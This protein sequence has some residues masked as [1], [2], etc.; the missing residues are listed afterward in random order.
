MK[1][2]EL[3]EKQY[4]KKTPR[5]EVGDTLSVD[6]IVREGNKKRIQVFTGIVLA[7]KGRGLNKTF[8]IR[9]ISSGIGV[10]KIFPL[11]S[12]NIE[13][14]TVV[15]SGKVRRSK[16]YYLRKREGKKALKVAEGQMYSDEEINVYEENIVTDNKEVETQ[17]SK[18][19]KSASALKS[20]NET[21]DSKNKDNSSK[22][23][24]T[25]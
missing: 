24:A 9:K 15:R 21:L 2:V 14:I 22:G 25:T 16:L 18:E 17:A 1:T 20:S 7:K 13:K 5:F 11:Y 19:N 12:P 3:I 10:E 8:T 4:I 6:T 23:K